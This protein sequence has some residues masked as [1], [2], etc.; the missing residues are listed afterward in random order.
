MRRR[1]WTTCSGRRLS[2]A[3]AANCSPGTADPAVRSFVE[4]NYGPWDRLDGNAPFV[5]GFGAKPPGAGFYPVDMTKEEFERADLPGKT[6]E[7]S[8]IRRDPA[9]K[10]TVV[11]YSVEWREPLGRAAGTIEKAAGSRRGPGAREVP[12]PASERRLRATNTGR[13]T[14]PGWT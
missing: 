10:L 11:P 2:R 12:R 7:Y 14:S 4:L 13:A 1:S 6:G 8:V 5:P 9:G 3:T